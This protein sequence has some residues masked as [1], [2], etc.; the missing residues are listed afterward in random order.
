MTR[1]ALTVLVSVGLTLLLGGAAL[2]AKPVREFVPS[3]P[4]TT[5]PAGAL[6]GFPVAVETL[7]NNEYLT[8]FSDG[9]Q[10][11]T[12]ALKLRLTNVDTG[13]S[14]V[15]NASGP[16]WYTATETTFNVSGQG[17]WVLFQFAGDEP[18]PGIFL[19]RGNLR[20]VADESG[21]RVL[22]STSSPRNLCED[23]A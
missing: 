20:F 3:P 16:G 4:D 9:R 17:R 8:T 11:I 7:R 1:F 12:G 23:L 14:L 6:C 15:V 13:E 18:G 22:S 19:Y 5:F 10:R 2:A 21:V